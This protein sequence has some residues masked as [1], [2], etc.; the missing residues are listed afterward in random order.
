MEHTTNPYEIPEEEPQMASE[1]AAPYGY[2]AN[3]QHALYKEGLEESSSEKKE[4]LRNHLHN[5]TAR[6]LESVDWM[7]N[8]PFPVY[9]DSSDDSWIDAAEAAGNTDI[10]DD[11]VIVKNRLAWQSLR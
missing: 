9:P 3:P 7:E 5:T 4:F 11:T 6:F 1:Q 10:V 8:K 2:S